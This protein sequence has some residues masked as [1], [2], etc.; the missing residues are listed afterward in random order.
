MPKSRPSHND[1]PRQTTIDRGEPVNPWNN[2]GGRLPSTLTASSREKNK[3]LMAVM[4][5]AALFA[6]MAPIAKQPLAKLWAFLPLEHG[7]L[8][9][10]NLLSAALLFGQHSLSRSRRVLV[11]ATGYLFCAFMVIAHGITF[12]GLVT[13]E[14][15]WAAGTRAS[16]W[17]YLF[18]HAGFPL[19]AIAYAVLADAPRAAPARRPLTTILLGTG[20]ALLATA[21]L[22]WTA[23]AGHSV[24]PVLFIDIRYS[25]SMLGVIAVVWLLSVG[26]LVALWLRQPY[27]VIDVWL[28]VVMSTWT[29]DIA[30][31]AALNTALFDAGFYAGRAFG[32]LSASVL[33]VIS[34]IES[35]RQQG[36]LM[37][38]HHA[39]QLKASEA[40]Q[41]HAQLE[42]LHAELTERNVQLEE[43]SRLKGAYLASMSH[44]LRTPL[45]AIIGFSEM[46]KD[47]LA[48]P[49]PPNQLTYVGHVYHSG[50]RLL[51]LINNILDLSR[52][53]SGK[54]DMAN[55]PIALDLLL[56]ESLAAIA[57]SAAAKQI[58]LKCDTQV[59]TGI[60]HA[61]RRRLR[62][63]VDNLLSNAL[64]FTRAGGSV[65]LRATLVQRAQAATA[66]PGFKQGVR[67]PLPQNEFATFVE[68]SISDTGVGLR[69]D[70]MARLFTPFT[71]V[72]NPLTRSPDG[73]GLGLAIVRRLAELHGGTVAVT[74]DVGRGSCFS[75]WLP[76]HAAIEARLSRLN[77]ARGH[78]EG[79]LALLIEQD[80]CAAA[81]MRSQLEAEGFRVQHVP[82]AE[83]A[84]KLACDCRPDVIA[85][86]VHLPGMDGWE[87]LSRQKALPQWSDIPV[88][89][90]SV[91]A[92]EGIGFSLGASMV[93]EKPVCPRALSDGMTRLGL[94]PQKSTD[95]TVLVIDDDPNAVEILASHLHQ[96]GYIVLCAFGGSEGI[97][98]ARHFLPD[99]IALDLQMPEVNGFDVVEAL[100]SHS[101]TAHIP[102]IIVT[103][104]ALS[105]GDRQQLNGHILDLVDKA[106]FKQDRFIGEVQRALTRQP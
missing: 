27:T 83:A 92:T 38:A 82:S 66:Q 12:P 3:A 4:A 85:L 78:T 47:G 81:L 21:L 9:V 53:E 37:A 55:E 48:G 97:E 94:V 11:L 61:D 102:V 50:H 77:P 79:P 101:S 88:V 22:T 49:M 89:V 72:L 24:L 105:D 33:P 74:S 40:R 28:L 23:T 26:A 71:H 2:E 29:F 65:S 17:L 25:P 5:S 73:T 59:G 93:L 35:T 63:I 90:V 30:L 100:K 99:L 68:I 104:R 86:D 58:R 96:S 84:L 42:A 20:V 76:W 36:Q 10:L 45:N 44:E 87:F 106:E 57:A 56:T 52:I 64:K 41:L 69:P 75:L 70:D 18:W 60:M 7:A 31:S 43:S 32:L 62:Q 39:E 6:V 54:L 103:A 1:A 14:G 16:A 8:V 19:F 95:V 67:M 91:S 13:P 51:A 15:L 98:M 80:E 46:M 34:L